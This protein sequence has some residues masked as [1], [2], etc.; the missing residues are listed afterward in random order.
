MFYFVQ[1]FLILYISSN[2]FSVNVIPRSLEILVMSSKIFI[3]FSISSVVVL[4]FTYLVS[5]RISEFV[6]LSIYIN[7]YIF[8]SFPLIKGFKWSCWSCSTCCMTRKSVLTLLILW[9]LLNVLQQLIYYRANQY[10]IRPIPLCIF[11]CMD[12]HRCEYSQLFSVV[13]RFML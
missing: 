10:M 1:K 12:N 2:S 6:S 7:N 3:L 8:L 4:I 13:R 11:L 5:F 9:D